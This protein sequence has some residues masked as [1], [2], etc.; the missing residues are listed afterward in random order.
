MKKFYY[1]LAGI[2]FW[3]ICF[4]P[5]ETADLKTYFLWAV[6]CLCILWVVRVIHKHVG[7]WYEG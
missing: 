4:V 3:T 2:L 7:V 6:Y 1:I 5:D